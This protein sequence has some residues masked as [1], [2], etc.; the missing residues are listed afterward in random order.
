MIEHRTAERMIVAGFLEK[1]LRLMP[2]DLY[3]RVA[4]LVHHRLEAM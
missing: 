3:E 4:A 2:E 1:T